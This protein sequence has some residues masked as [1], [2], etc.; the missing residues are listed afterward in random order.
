MQMLMAHKTVWIVKPVVSVT[1]LIPKAMLFTGANISQTQM[2]TNMTWR[3]TEDSSSTIL[4][5]V[6]V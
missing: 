5:C 4:H 2:H 6:V 3:H 1:A